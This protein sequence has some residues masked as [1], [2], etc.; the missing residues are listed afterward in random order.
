[1]GRKDAAFCAFR[2]TCVKSDKLPS[3]DVTWVKINL[4]LLS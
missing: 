4:E 1:M 2:G 3:S